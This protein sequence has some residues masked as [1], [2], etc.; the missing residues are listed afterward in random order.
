MKKFLRITAIVIVVLVAIVFA[1]GFFLNESKPEGTPGPEAD[2]LARKMM[3]AIDHA[4]W[5][6]TALVSWDFGG[7]QQHIWDRERHFAEVRWADGEENFRSQVDINA[8]TGLLWKNGEAVTDPAARDKGVDFAWKKWVNDSFWLNPVSKVFD[9][10]TERSLVKLDDGSEALMITYTSGGDTPGDSYLWMLDE[11]G[12]PT[13]WKMWVSIIPIGGME[14]TWEDW[15]T[16]D[17]GVKL[18][19]THVGPFTLKL[20]DIQVADSLGKM[21][22]EGDPFA[23]LVE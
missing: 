21:F 11:N 2:A 6:T 10:G 13:S 7:R 17:T 1:A 15:Q 9:P 8:R 19:E 22:P 5:D 16:F 20:T 23:E 3:A 14:F 18:S 4:A 12:L